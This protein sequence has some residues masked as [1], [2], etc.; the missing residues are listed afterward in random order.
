MRH[1]FSSGFDVF[2]FFEV[3][4][5]FLLKGGHPYKR[6]LGNRTFFGFKTPFIFKARPG[7]EA[8]LET[9][10]SFC[11]KIHKKRVVNTSLQAWQGPKGFTD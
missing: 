5:S 2:F 10:P 9:G 4:H 8:S 3:L 7:K 6:D 11:L 1:Q